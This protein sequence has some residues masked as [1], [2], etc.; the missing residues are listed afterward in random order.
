MP[1]RLYHTTLIL[2]LYSCIGNEK[3]AFR[4][5]DG[6]W[7]LGW[8]RIDPLKWKMALLATV[9]LH[10]LSRPLQGVPHQ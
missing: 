8:N 6:F 7:K 1:G 9:P 4:L 3:A 5:L 10:S 2:I